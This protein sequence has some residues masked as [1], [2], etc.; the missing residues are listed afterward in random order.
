MSVLEQKTHVSTRHSV[1]HLE[2]QHLEGGGD[3]EFKAILDYRQTGGGREGGRK[4]GRESHVLLFLVLEK[5]MA[6]GGARH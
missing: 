4:G 3:K 1:T 2:S 5:F 6:S